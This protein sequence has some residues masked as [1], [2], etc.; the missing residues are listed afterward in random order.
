MHLHRNTLVYHL[1][2][3]E[4]IMD[5][6]LSDANVIQLF[7]LSFRLLEYDKQIERKE[8]WNDV[9]EREQ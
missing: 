4:E 9:P 5:V 2:R 7:D 6:S 3:I 8:K 1:K